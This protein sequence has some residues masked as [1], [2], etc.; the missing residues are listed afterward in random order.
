[1]MVHSFS[2]LGDLKKN[3]SSYLFTDMYIH[4]SHYPTIYFY[5]SESWGYYI[6][7][8]GTEDDGMYDKKNVYMSMTGL[9]CCAAEI[10]MIL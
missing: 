2:L 8:L 4:F 9:L 3:H 10:D 6:Q 1:M 7:S 5:S